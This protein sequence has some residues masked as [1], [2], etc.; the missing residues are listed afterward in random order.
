MKC[1]AALLLCLL[2]SL[3]LHAADALSC[4]LDV[5][6]NLGWQ[7]VADSPSPGYENT[8]TCN[9]DRTPVFKYNTSSEDTATLLTRSADSLNSVTSKCLYNRNYQ[10]AVKASVEKLSNNAEFKFLPVGDDPRDPFLPPE[11]TWDTKSARGYDIPLSSITGSINSLYEKPFVAECSTAAQIAQLAALTEHYGT[12]ADSMLSLKEVGIGTW[13]QYAR[14]PSIAAKQS[15]FIDRK[16]RR[17]GGL[18]KLASYGRAAF[19]GQI[20]YIKPYKGIDYVD[21]LDN[22]GQNY[23]IVNLTD[24]AVASIKA[25]KKPLKEL[26]K[27]SRN[28]WKK[29]R[30]LQTKGEPMEKL[31]IDMQAEL[32]AADPFFRDIEIYVHPLRTKNF[33]HHIA[34]QFS[35]NS[36]TPYVFEVYEDYQPGF[37]YN[38]FI[39]H[40]M[41]ECLQ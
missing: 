41:K 4:R 7:T 13:R 22:L 34:R 21:S 19:Y 32:E 9:T 5:L 35:Y 30:Q 18:A 23:V 20:G 17:K 33:A 6:R 40:S 31:V 3:P 15:L 28:M 36:R 25:R 2:P 14:S 12:T 37:F 38:R 1:N 29:Y 26:S 16:A 27:V 11:G 8:N 10:T 39:E 24:L